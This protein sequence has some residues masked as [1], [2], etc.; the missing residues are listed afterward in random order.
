MEI[1]DRLESE[2][3]SYCR[4]F[5]T[6]FTSALGYHLVDEAGRRYIDFFSGAGTLNYGHNHPDI[7]RELVDYLQGDGVLHS[8]DMATAAKRRFLEFFES[9]ILAPRRLDYKVQF[10]G[11]TGTNAVEAALKLARKATGR[12]NVVYFSRSYHGMTLGALAVTANAKKRSGAGVPLAFTV[13]VPYENDL[14]PEVDGLVYLEGLLAD[15]AGGVDLPAAVIVETVQAEG[16]V[17]SASWSW[18]RRLDQLVRRF[19]VLLIVDD[20]Q[21]GCG[22]TGPFFSFEPAGILPDLVTLSK[23]ISGIGLPMSLLLIRPQ[24]DVWSPGEHTGT[25][26]GNNLAFVA[27]AAALSLFWRDDALS[28]E[29]ERKAALLEAWAEELLHSH[30]AARGELRGRGLIQGISFPSPGLA[31]QLAR[32]AFDRGLIIE[33]AGRADE[34]LKILPPL[35]IDEAGLKAGLERLEDCLRSLGCEAVELGR[36]AG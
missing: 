19:G 22:R 4:S 34:V 1:F 3:R 10:C 33:T 18:L 5:P 14:G 32:A 30:P 31:A 29:V 12:T 21:V 7:K 8:L 11:P 26:R 2:V 17:H 23:S 36:G 27:G 28:R 25:F 24:L 6:V 16:G 9:L 20:I 13:A 15:S 35:I